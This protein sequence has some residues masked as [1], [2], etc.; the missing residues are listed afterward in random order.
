[1]LILRII[2]FKNAVLISKISESFYPPLFLLML[3]LANNTI[4]FSKLGACTHQEYKLAMQI[5]IEQY[6]C[7]SV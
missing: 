5:S 7:F 2:F 6:F 4:M 3:L 1:M